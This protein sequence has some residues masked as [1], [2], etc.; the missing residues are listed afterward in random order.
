MA[1]MIVVDTEIPWTTCIET[2]VEGF[3]V[4]L[5]RVSTFHTSRPP[6]HEGM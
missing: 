1:L 4:L 3:A 2:V 5:F 6:F